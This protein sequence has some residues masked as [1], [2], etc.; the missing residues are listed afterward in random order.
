MCSLPIDSAHG[1]VYHKTITSDHTN[2]PHD[3]PQAGKEND[4]IELAIA[5]AA[6]HGN[7]EEAKN[8]AANI[9]S[10]NYE[11]Y[12]EIWTALEAL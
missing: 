8:D 4:M 3:R 10:S 1:I 5:Y 7:T 11:E 6:A 2:Q 9:Y 12:M